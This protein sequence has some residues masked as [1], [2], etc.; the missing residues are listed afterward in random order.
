MVTACLVN[1]L[2]IVAASAAVRHPL[3]IR[4]PGTDP[5]TTNPADVSIARTFLAIAFAARRDRAAPACTRNVTGP[6]ATVAAAVAAAADD[7]VGVVAFGDVTTVVD[8]VATAIREPIVAVDTAVVAFAAAVLAA[9]VVFAVVD[10]V[11]ARTVGR[12]ETSDLWFVASASLAAITLPT[13]TTSTTRIRAGRNIMASS[14]RNDQCDT[15]SASRRGIA[16]SDPHPM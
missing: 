1:P 4:N 11:A 9:A 16:R 14:A 13:A 15:P 7:F 10:V 5:V 6:A 3:T 8:V 12:D 2:A